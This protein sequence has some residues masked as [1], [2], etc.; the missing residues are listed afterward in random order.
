[1]ALLRKATLQDL[2]TIEQLTEEAKALMIKDDNPQWDHRYPLKTH[3]NTD[4]ESG[5]LFVYDEDDVI[6]GFIV[7]D[8]Q[9]PDWYDTL[10][11]PVD[12][13][14]AYVIHRLV[15]SPQYRGTAQALM[16]FAIA[17]AKEHNIDILLTD[18]FSQNQRAQ[19]LFDKYGFI[20]TGEMTSTEFPFDKGKPFY[21]YYKKLTE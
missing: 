10:E 18:T 1:M 19:R 14:Q 8:Q 16:T 21:A 15:A 4:I 20:K 7:I 6:Q 3:F 17:L 12:K 2:D 13:S 5:S 11:W 9:A